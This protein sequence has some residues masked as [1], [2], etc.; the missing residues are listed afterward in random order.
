MKLK[1]PISITIYALLTVVS[2]IMWIPY[3][4]SV[5]FFGCASLVQSFVIAVSLENIILSRIILSWLFVFSVLL[6]TF[7]FIATIKKKFFPFIVVAG[8]DIIM[9]LML[10]SICIF[11]SD[12]INQNTW[13][14]LIG[15]VTRTIYFVYMLI[16][17]R[18]HSSAK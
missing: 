5:H 14:I 1:K 7:Y 16:D 8:L 2:V 17:A 13:C 6:L 4:D 15:C 11:T 12:Y 3:P 18:S 10:A 9:S